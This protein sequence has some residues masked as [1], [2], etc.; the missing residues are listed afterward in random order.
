VTRAQ[1]DLGTASVLES[2]GR[3]LTNIDHAPELDDGWHLRLE[4]NTKGL[5]LDI[6][7]LRQ[8]DARQ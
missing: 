3:V 4:W 8:N 6:R 1:G 5:L 2:L 7:I